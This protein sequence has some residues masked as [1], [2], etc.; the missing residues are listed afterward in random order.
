MPS[1]VKWHEGKAGEHFMSD[2]RMRTRK[3]DTTQ[4]TSR[5]VCELRVNTSLVRCIFHITKKEVT[6][7]HMTCCFFDKMKEKIIDSGTRY[8][9]LT[10]RGK[11]SEQ[12]RWMTH[13]ILLSAPTLEL[14]RLGIGFEHRHFSKR[15]KTGQSWVTKLAGKSSLFGSTKV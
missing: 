11:E 12:Y 8:S 6:I 15:V 2:C 1:I 5:M 9:T 3:L 4:R 14:K 13:H 7:N 10:S